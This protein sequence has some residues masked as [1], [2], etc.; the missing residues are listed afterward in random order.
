MQLPSFPFRGISF[1]Y[2]IPRKGKCQE[3][4]LFFIAQMGKMC[5]TFFKVE[6]FHM[7]IASRLKALREENGL[8]QSDLAQETGLSKKSIINYENGYRQPNSKAMAILEQFFN[9]S[10]SYLRGE[11]D[12][13]HERRGNNDFN[14]VTQN[15]ENNFDVSLL[16][17]VVA[18]ASHSLPEVQ[19]HVQR[20]LAQIEHVLDYKDEAFIIDS[21]QLYEHL[22][23]IGVDYTSS[24]HSDLIME[25]EKVDLNSKRGLCISSISDE[26]KSF[27][28]I[29]YPSE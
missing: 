17:N 21:L 29:Y 22:G 23:R 13:R 7:S 18:L 15:D 12:K 20:I 6:V 1:L 19:I 9:V 5:Y 25:E 26:F 16:Q 28:E 14:Y 11:S 4:I 3:F 8:S 2:Y 10:G 24:M 27:Q